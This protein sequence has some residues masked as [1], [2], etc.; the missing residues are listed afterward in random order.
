MDYKA[1]TVNMGRSPQSIITDLWVSY[2]LPYSVTV[3]PERSV[4]CRCKC[5]TGCNMTCITEE[6]FQKLNI[7]YFRSIGITTPHG[8]QSTTHTARVAMMIP[9]GQ[10]LSDIEV[11]IA[12]MPETD[13][14]VGM[15]IISQGDFAIS[16]DMYG[17][18]IFSICMPP[19]M[20]I[21]LSRVADEVN[22]GK[23]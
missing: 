15:D 23:L 9:N 5:D 19:L 2:P 22:K 17:D 7:P 3:M 14:L 1:Y 18:L 10:I 4:K 21:D 6:L 16:H 20:T 11:C 12:H 8:T 13:V